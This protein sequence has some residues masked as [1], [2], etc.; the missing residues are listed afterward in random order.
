MIKKLI[1][2]SFFDR[3]ILSPGELGSQKACPSLRGLR[4][5]AKSTHSSLSQE[6]SGIFFCFQAPNTLLSV[7]KDFL[8]RKE[9]LGRTAFLSART[10]AL[11]GRVRFRR[12]PLPLPQPF[13][14]TTSHGKNSPST[15]VYNLFKN[16]DL[17]YFSATF[18]FHLPQIHELNTDFIFFLFLDATNFGSD[19]QIKAI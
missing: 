6:I 4:V 3:K 5:G 10:V 1:R 19:K 12:A 17:F 7:W 11:L 16:Y 8:R 15:D 14:P 2:Y 13:P 9:W 18:T